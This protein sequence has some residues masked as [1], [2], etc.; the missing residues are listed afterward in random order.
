MTLVF[1]LWQP[2][3]GLF[4]HHLSVLVAG[5]CFPALEESTV[6][7]LITP[8]EGVHRDEIRLQRLALERHTPPIVK[9]RTYFFQNLR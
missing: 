1:S 8:I 2:G 7:L 4:I 5:S 6:C 3:Y 9:V